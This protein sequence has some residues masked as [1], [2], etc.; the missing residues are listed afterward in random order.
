[1]KKK[2]LAIGY[3]A[4]IVLLFAAIITTAVYYLILHPSHEGDMDP[5][6]K[7]LL[8]STFGVF[9][10]LHIL[11]NHFGIKLTDV[12]SSKKVERVI[13]SVGKVLGWIVVIPIALIGVIIALPFY[14]IFGGEKRAF[15][16]LI[17]K[18]YKL[19]KNRA[20]K[21]YVL[22]SERV[23]IKVDYSF[24]Q[25]LV[26]IDGGAFIPLI[27]SDIGT[28]SEREKL[29]ELVAKYESAHPLDKQ[30]GD[31][32]PPKAEFVDFLCRNLANNR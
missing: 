29:G 19:S 3:I 14:L 20:E 31:A 21:R 26:S 32:R 7:I 2:V 12:T 28:A 17:A 6:A 1:M 16:P 9:A 8:F 23:I 13:D 10:V 11:V 22:T 4:S 25:W 15:K 18:G 27:D 24:C 5:W 30:R